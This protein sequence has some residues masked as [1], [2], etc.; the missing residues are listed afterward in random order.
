MTE[1]PF[2]LMRFCSLAAIFFIFVGSSDVNV[3]AQEVDSAMPTIGKP[4]TKVHAVSLAKLALSGLDREF[5]NKPSNVLAG[6]ESIV[7][8]RKMFPAF[9]GCFDWHSSVHGHWM[10]VRILKLHPDIEIAAEI[11]HK[12]S[13]HLSKENLE[14]EAAFFADDTNKSF[15]RMYG[16]AWL[17]RLSTELHA[18]TDD[19]GQRWRENL[20]PLENVLTNRINAYLPLLTYPIRTGEHPDTG[21]ALGQ[22][23]DYSRAVGNDALTDLV[24][25]RSREFYFNDVQYPTRYEPSG[26]DFFSTGWNEADLMRRVLSETEF[27]EWLTRFL[28]ELSDGKC[29][30][31]LTPAIVTDV[32]DGKLVHLAGLNLSRAWCQSA[33]ARSLPKNDPRIEILDK[34]AQAHVEAGLKF[35]FSGH[36]EGEHWLGTFA[37]YALTLSGH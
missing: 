1:T 5:P 13:E 32:T 16:W 24:V 4:L 8:P 15:E 26:Q 22:V 21:F 36:Y 27:A 10:L 19:D 11:R 3:L 31:L 23:L 18:W 35:V 37:I 2:R 6:P 7:E 17:L 9:Y 25:R 30:N 28:P 12:L 20:L 29:G 34:A 33:I 14:R